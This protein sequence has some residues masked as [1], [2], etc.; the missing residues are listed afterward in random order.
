L[1]SPK[2]TTLKQARDPTSDVEGDIKLRFEGYFDK[3]ERDVI[4]KESYTV[5]Q[6]LVSHNQAFHQVPETDSIM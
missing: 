5:G 4:I 6:K 1:Q 3:Q 2:K